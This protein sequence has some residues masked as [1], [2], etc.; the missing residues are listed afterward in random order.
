MKAVSPSTPETRL[1]WGVFNEADFPLEEIEVQGSGQKRIF[2]GRT[3]YRE[4]EAE[5]ETG[6]FLTM[7]G[8]I[9]FWR[10]VRDAVHAWDEEQFET[11]DSLDELWEGKPWLLKIRR[12][13]S[14]IEAA[15]A[16]LTQRQEVRG[17]A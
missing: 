4:R 12:M 1:V 10:W 7:G 13:K 9:T 16:Q 17:S 6:V 3:L 2:S 15:Y 8:K 11:Y 14:G 5:E